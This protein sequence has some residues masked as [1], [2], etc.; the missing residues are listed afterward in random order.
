M[1]PR[2]KNKR[3][4]YLNKQNQCAV[5]P[6]KMLFVQAVQMESEDI[7]GG[8]DLWNRSAL[9]LEW[10]AEGVID[11]ES[12]DNVKCCKAIHFV[13]LIYSWFKSWLIGTDELL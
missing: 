5:S 8:K 9:S 10:K 1:L 6:V 4:N 13:T 11:D 3:R 7:Y 12:D 2:D